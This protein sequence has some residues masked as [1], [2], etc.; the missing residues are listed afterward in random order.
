MLTPGDST[1]VGR[2]V[3]YRLTKLRELG[4]L[5]GSW[6]DCGSADGG[7][8]GALLDHGASSAVGV[9]LDPARVE[10]ARRRR[11]HVEFVVGI[12]EQLPFDDCSFDGVLLNEV[13][14]HV[15]DER[16]ALREI[17]RVLR[18]GGALALYSP[19]RWFPVEGH[20]VQWHGRLFDHPA[21]LVPWLPYRVTRMFLRARNYWPWELR[22]LCERAGLETIAVGTAFP[23]FEIYRWLPRS[24]IA[25]YHRVLPALE[26]TPVVRWLGVS[27]L[28]VA[29]RP[30]LT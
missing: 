9:E 17:R 13:L 3:S 2:I 15:A 23:Q 14:E 30:R 11:P 4:V 1:A 22:Q 21:P 24:L 10:E 27:V 6:L 29:R 19:N 18:P 25:L 5:H 8:A 28:I 12:A 16:A 7:Y 26:R 20:G